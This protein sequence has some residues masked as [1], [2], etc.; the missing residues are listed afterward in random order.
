MK[1]IATGV[2]LIT[3]LPVVVAQTSSTQQSASSTRAGQ[4]K[5]ASQASASK[6][7]APSSENMK[8]IPNCEQADRQLQ[9][10][11]NRAPH[12]CRKNADCDGYYLSANSCAP[13]VVLR[14][15]GV[16]RDRE[17]D[18]LRLQ[19]QARSACAQQWS[20]QPACSP[21]PFRAACVEDRCI[22]RM[23]PQATKSHKSR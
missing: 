1:K 6:R 16:S 11:L 2:L 10:F 3:V 13:A 21:I 22:D 7:S 9:Q 18:L 23:Q 4:R 8:S 12:S 19:S 20:K 5:T 15:P 17:P 14:R